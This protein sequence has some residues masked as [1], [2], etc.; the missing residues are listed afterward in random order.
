M[1]LLMIF[2]LF[3]LLF[4]NSVSLKIEC[5]SKSSKNCSGFQGSLCVLGA[6]TDG[7]KCSL[8]GALASEFNSSCSVRF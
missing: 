7:K 4:Q 2:F 6:R 1:F 5:R 3:S 8:V